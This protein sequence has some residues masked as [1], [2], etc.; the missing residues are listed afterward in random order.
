MPK[1]ELAEVVSFRRT[2]EPFGGLSNMASGYPLMVN[3]IRF[4]TSEALYQACKFPDYPNL[5]RI[6]INE[7]SPMTAK[8]R[9]KPFEDKVRQDWFDVRVAIMEWCLCVKLYQH[10]NGFGE[11]LLSTNGKVIVEDSWKDAFWGAKRNGNFFVGSNVLGQLLMRLR[12]FWNENR[13]KQLRPFLAPPKVANAYLLGEPIESIA[14]CQRLEQEGS[15]I[16]QRKE[17]KAKQNMQYKSRSLGLLD[18]C[19]DSQKER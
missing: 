1:Y 7:S 4:S 14:H 8:M 13:K 15:A 18:I 5:Q 16:R 2:S 17:H 9:A 19:S 10:P 3:G 12:S 11:L 6:I